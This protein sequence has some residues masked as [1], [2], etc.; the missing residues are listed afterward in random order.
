VVVADLSLAEW[1]VLAVVD[2]QPTH[3]FAI[4]GLVAP[5]GDLGRVWHIPKPVVYRALGRLETCGSIALEGVERAG[6][7][8]RQR[9]RATSRGSAEV[10]GWLEAPVGH[11]RD[12][13]SAFLLKLALLDRRG[14]DHR[15][16]VHAQ[17]EVLAPISAAV[18]DPPDE[19]GF[20]AVL[21]AWRRENLAAAEHF[22]AVLDAVDAAAAPATDCE[23][24]GPSPGPRRGAR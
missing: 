21:A 4:S 23:G 1:V 19:Q 6:G 20:D 16:L 9:Y 18:G 10:A 2:E 7:P 15:T 5:D 8:Q 13:R 11:V 14:R 12:L 17:R 24:G 22:L 3:G